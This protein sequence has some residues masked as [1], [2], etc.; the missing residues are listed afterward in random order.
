MS[1]HLAGGPSF[2][3]LWFGNLL[4]IVYLHSMPSV[5]HSG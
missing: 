2:R 5:F 1:T 3:L 4:T